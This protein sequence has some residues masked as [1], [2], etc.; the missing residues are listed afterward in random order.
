M[1]ANFLIMSDEKYFHTIVKSIGRLNL[2]YPRSQIYFYDW[3]VGKKNIE[4]LR[5]N[6]K[7][8]IV[9]DWAKNVNKVL[10]GE[11]CYISDNLSKDQLDDLIIGFRN[12][13]WFIKLF[14]KFRLTVLKSTSMKK[15]VARGIVLENL[16][17]TK[18]QCQMD[19]SKRVGNSEFV[20]LDADALLIDRIDE[21]YDESFDFAFTLRRE[22]EI[23][24]THNLCTV[25]NVG[26]VFFGDNQKRRDLFLEKW[27]DSTKVTL[28]WIREQTALTRYLSQFD[29]FSF[30]SNSTYSIV[31]DGEEVNVRLL[32]CEIYNYNWI[33]DVISNKD[34]LKKI[35]VLHFKGN[36]HDEKTFSKLLSKLDL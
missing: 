32:P 1:P 18:I 14:D 33:E 21:V 7:N 5:E 27:W 13:R 20:F 2:I 12:P 23:N 29:C 25:I 9:V 3:G 11:T 34:L 31:I 15:R 10:S 16:Y 28:E 22:K 36:R 8:I 4:Y 24:F 19:M 26:V 35:K 30:K 17:L 6:F